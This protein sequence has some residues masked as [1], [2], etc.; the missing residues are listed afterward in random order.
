MKAHVKKL[1]NYKEI[2]KD[3]NFNKIL[4]VKQLL[5]LENDIKNKKYE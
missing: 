3:E 1:V 2:L 5:D 4:I